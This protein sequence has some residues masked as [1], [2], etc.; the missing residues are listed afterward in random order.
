MSENKTPK[1]DSAF[2]GAGLLPARDKL[3]ADIFRAAMA[4]LMPTWLSS[5][6]L[7]TFEKEKSMSLKETFKKAVIHYLR[8]NATFV[9]WSPHIFSAMAFIAQFAA[10]EA[11]PFLRAAAAISKI[12][13]PIEKKLL[14]DLADRIERGEDL[15]IGALLSEAFEDL[16]KDIDQ[17]LPEIEKL[18]PEAAAF[19][20]KLFGKEDGPATSPVFGS[21]PLLPQPA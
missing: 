19:I 20:R 21:K 12:S 7:R 3:L 18:S 2:S 5:G 16:K 15:N 13:S 11:Y 4:Q 10:P 9:E 17:I 14:N 8:D 1:V 6:P